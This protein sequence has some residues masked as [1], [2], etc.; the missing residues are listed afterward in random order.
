[1]EKFTKLYKKFAQAG[2]SPNEQVA[3]AYMYDR[4]ELSDGNSNFYDNQHNAYYITYSRSELSELLNVSET[5]VSSIFKSLI[6][7][8]WIIVKRRF[9]STNRIFLPKLLKS[10]NCTSKIQKFDSNY[11]ELNYTDK[12]TKDTKDTV[13]RVESS[14][15][16][17]QYQIDALADSLIN[18]AGMSEHTVNILKTFS[19]NDTDKLYNYASLLFKAKK[20]V[21]N[22]HKDV[23]GINTSS[24]FET[25]ETL[26]NELPKLLKTLIPNAERNAKNKTGYIFKGL[27]NFFEEN[28]DEFLQNQRKI[29]KTSNPI[30]ELL[31]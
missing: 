6:N 2:L 29:K 17:N 20:C 14:K 24:R 5:T 9:N 16:D 3:L 19:F 21:F 4:M 13:N 23:S 11:T 7:K 22:A 25:N 1:M 31:V 18:S 12:S 30:T 28:F 8:G 15:N 10:K 27:Y 26:N